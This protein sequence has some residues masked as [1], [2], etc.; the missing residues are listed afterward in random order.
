MPQLWFLWRLVAAFPEDIGAAELAILKAWQDTAQFRLPDNFQP[1]P[2]PESLPGKRIGSALKSWAQHSPRPLVIFIDEIDSLQ[3]NVL[4]SATPSVARRLP[5]QA[6]R[7]SS[8][9]STHWLA[10]CERL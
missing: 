6:G 8:L 5:S 9:A 2:W 10:G 7:I 3:G 4:L 1:P